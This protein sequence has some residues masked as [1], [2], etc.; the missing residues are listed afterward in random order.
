MPAA[1]CVAGS[2]DPVQSG[3][4]VAAGVGVKIPFGATDGTAGSNGVG[5]TT[6]ARADGETTRRCAAGS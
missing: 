4:G 1:A 3:R 2:G 6:T 5:E